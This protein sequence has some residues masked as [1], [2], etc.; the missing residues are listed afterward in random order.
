MTHNAQHNVYMPLE[1]RQRMN[2]LM[3]IDNPPLN[4]DED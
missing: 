1:E 4:K 2:L 3:K